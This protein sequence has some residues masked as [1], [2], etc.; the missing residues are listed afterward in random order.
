MASGCGEDEPTDPSTEEP[1][2][3]NDAL[4]LELS[5]IFAYETGAAA[6][7]GEAAEQADGFAKHAREHVELLRE[8]IEELGGT[9]VKERSDDF[10]RRDLALDELDDAEDAEE[11]FLNIAADLSNMA[12]GTYI[13]LATKLTSAPL[14]RTAFEIA[15][16]EAEQIS[17]VLGELGEPQVPDALVVGAQP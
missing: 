17:V 16:V 10:Y 14:R 15:A 4:A 11:V 5:A 1:D 12:V 7:S 3:L 6:L 8:D 13:E 2:L 9:P